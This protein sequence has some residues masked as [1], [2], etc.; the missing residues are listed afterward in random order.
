MPVWQYRFMASLT[1]LIP[2]SLV[3]WFEYSNRKSID[4]DKGFYDNAFSAKVVKSRDWH[5]RGEEFVLSNGYE[6]LF[7]K[8]VKTRVAIGDS[9]TKKANSYKYEV[10]RIGEDGTYNFVKTFSLQ[11]DQTE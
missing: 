4:N 3:I 9:I 2:I 11:G 10:Y 7:P 5:G 6:I 8:Y 1:F